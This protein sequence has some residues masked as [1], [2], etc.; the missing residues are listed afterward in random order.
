MAAPAGDATSD[1]MGAG[2]KGPAESAPAA[3]PMSFESAHAAIRGDDKLQFELPVVKPE[4]PP[5]PPP[6]ND[7][8]DGLG[9]LFAAIGPAASII[10]WGAVFVVAAAFLFFIG[11]EIIRLRYG[12]KPKP[13][14]EVTVPEWRPDEQVARTLLTEADRLAA[15][16][17]FAEAVRLLLIRSIEDFDSRRPHTVRRAYTSR[18][19][20]SLQ[21][22][23]EAA[24]PAFVKIAQ[25]VERSLFGGAAVDRAT[26]DDCRQ[27]YEAFALPAGWTR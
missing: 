17:R 9:D 20:A 16:G 12:G 21:A 22:L 18:E 10:F 6:R 25:A 2:L 13:K 19:I 27:A 4:A 14:P 8:W 11:R 24:R 26:F 1:S 3:E 5:P 15:E 7:G 23:P